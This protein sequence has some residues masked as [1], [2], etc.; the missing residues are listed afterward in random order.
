MKAIRIALAAAALTAISSIGFAADA[1]ANG[2]S[3]VYAT[4]KSASAKTTLSTRIDV[5]P[6]RQGG[7]SDAAKQAVRD[8]RPVAA[9][10]TGKF[11]RA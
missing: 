10:L 11:G 3:S 7:L 4:G 1:N 6:G 2:R 5:V 9:E 8:T